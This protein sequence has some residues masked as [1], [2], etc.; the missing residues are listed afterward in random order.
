[1]LFHQR[2]DLNRKV[3]IMVKYL[4][5]QSQYVRIS[6]LDVILLFIVYLVT[7]MM[8]LIFPMETVSFEICRH[9]FWSILKQNSTIYCYIPGNFDLLELIVNAHDVIFTGN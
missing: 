8:K 4:S 6:L 7:L 9:R 1:M 2:Y 3:K 5:Y